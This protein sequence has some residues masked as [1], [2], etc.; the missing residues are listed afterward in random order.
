MRA[1]TRGDCGAP[2]ADGH[3][4]SASNTW[5]RLTL[6]LSNQPGF[7]EVDDCLYSDSVSTCVGDSHPGKHLLG[8][9]GDPSAVPCLQRPIEQS[10]RLRHSVRTTPR[11][12]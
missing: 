5:Y 2:Q 1:N 12:P 9:R 4:Y 10:Y 7:A 11:S 8:P 3:A 6:L